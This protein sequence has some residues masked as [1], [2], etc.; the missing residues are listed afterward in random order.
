MGYCMD[1]MDQKFRIKK[2]NFDAALQAIKKLGETVD[3]DGRGGSYSGGQKQETWY[4]WVTTSEFVN[5]ETLKQAIAAWRW[6][7]EVEKLPFGEEGDIIDIYFEGQKFGQD[8]V[9]LEAIAPYVEE[10][11]YIEMQGECGARWRWLFKDGGL[12]EQSATIIWE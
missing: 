11:S 5:A 8:E 3:E 1:Q 4:S 2:E 10:G 12:K 7:V 9:F 6:E